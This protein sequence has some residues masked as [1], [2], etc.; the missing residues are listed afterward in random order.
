MVIQTQLDRLYFAIRRLV[1]LKVPSFCTTYLSFISLGVMQS[2]FINQT[3]SAD[4]IFRAMFS[5]L[6]LG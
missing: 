6:N 5:R 1:R 4:R 3:E 2:L